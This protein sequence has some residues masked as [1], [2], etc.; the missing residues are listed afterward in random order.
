MPTPASP[1]AASKEPVPLRWGPVSPGHRPPAHSATIC[2]LTPGLVHV[3]PGTPLSPFC[4]CCR[5]REPQH[6]HTAPFT[7]PKIWE[8]C[9]SNLGCPKDLI[10][11]PLRQ[12]LA[13]P[14]TM[15]RP[16]SPLPSVGAQLAAARGS[17]H[18]PQ[19]G[20]AR[21]QGAPGGPDTR[22]P[23]SH[24]PEDT[25]ARGGVGGVLSSRPAR[26]LN[27]EAGANRPQNAENRLQD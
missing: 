23:R 21:G 5:P 16:T 2:V 8:L 22:E 26:R 20:L 19:R 12:A 10:Q 14:S 6:P 7:S 18:C 3:H 15:A 24:S 25:D 11:V 1:S 13:D 27:S 17:L 4:S 9:P